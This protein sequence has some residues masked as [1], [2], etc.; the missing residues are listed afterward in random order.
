MQADKL[1]D[2]LCKRVCNLIEISE[3]GSDEV[4][5]IMNKCLQLDYVPM[6]LLRFYTYSNMFELQDSE[7]IQSLVDGPREYDVDFRG[8]KR[9][10]SFDEHTETVRLHHNVYADVKMRGSR[11]ILPESMSHPLQPT[12]PE[13]KHFEPVHRKHYED[14]VLGSLANYYRRVQDLEFKMSESDR[15]LMDSLM[16]M[17]LISARTSKGICV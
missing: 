1:L 2:I 8:W 7:L 6:Q 12:Y 17:S 5:D 16:D 3:I 15:K 14:S 10:L 11:P 9:P 13:P 4:L